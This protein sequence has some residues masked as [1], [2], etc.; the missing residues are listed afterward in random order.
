MP[1]KKPVPAKAPA[2]PVAKPAAKP[3]AG[4][5]APVAK[6]GPAPAAGVLFPLFCMINYVL[7]TRTRVSVETMLSVL[8]K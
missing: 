7:C 1:P 5:G 3:A 2:K 6:K 4:R 8:E